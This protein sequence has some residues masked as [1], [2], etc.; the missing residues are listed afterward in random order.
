[1]E[2]HLQNTEMM[3]C[4]ASSHSLP[5]ASFNMTRGWNYTESAPSNDHNLVIL[6][7]HRKA[8]RLLAVQ[9]WNLA[10]SSRKPSI[11]LFFSSQITAGLMSC[12]WGERGSSYEWDLV[13][14]E[15]KC[16]QGRAARLATASTVNEEIWLAWPECDPNKNKNAALKRCFIFFP[17]QKKKKPLKDLVVYTVADSSTRAR[18][19]H[20][21]GHK[22]I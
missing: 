19:T 18:M 11:A 9:V 13:W 14:D 21:G 16:F 6:K 17:T 8:D 7:L 10:D 15:R 3:V 4:D 20:P 22:Q 1:M 5:G 12:L 2:K